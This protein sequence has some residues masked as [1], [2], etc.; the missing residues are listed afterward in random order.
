MPICYKQTPCNYRIIPNIRIFFG[1][2][3]CVHIFYIKYKNRHDYLFIKI[4]SLCYFTTRKFDDIH[5]TI[6]C[7]LRSIATPGSSP[8]L[9]LNTSEF[10]ASQQVVDRYCTISGLLA[11][12]K[13]ESV[14][15]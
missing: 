13:P 14:F 11:S 7:L 3:K 10:L 4:F 12:S 6:P 5:Q 15:Q 2:S 8:L 9:E 1:C